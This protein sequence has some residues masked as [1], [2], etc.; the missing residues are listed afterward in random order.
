MPAPLISIITPAYNHEKYIA[1]CIRSALAQ[2]YTNWEMI[3]IDDGSTDRTGAIA[4]SFHDPRIRYLSQTHR[5]PYKL[6]EIYNK[7]L[8]ESKG[9]FIAILEGDDFWPNDKLSRQIASFDQQD[10]ILSYG[11]CIIVDQYGLEL[12]YRPIPADKNIRDNTPLGSALK[13]LLRAENFIYAQTVMIRKT[14]LLKSGG[15][16]QPNY[17]R[18]VDF[19]TWCC[20]ALQGQF[21]AIPNTLGYWRRNP[22][23]ITLSDPLVVSDEFV[24]YIS[25]FLAQRRNEIKKLLPDI[26][27]GNLIAENQTRLAIAQ[28]QRLYTKG[29]T[30][31]IY[32]YNQPARKSFGLYLRQPDKNLFNSIISLLFIIFSYTDLLK[33][34]LLGIGIYSNRWLA[35]IKKFLLSGSSGQE[36]S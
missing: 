31:L 1:D 23:S 4:G 16:I 33:I 19:P 3:I 35:S 28:S 14:A 8:K 7:A 24:R 20:L 2:T 34:T 26:N 5:G 32:G 15:F 13:Q 29:L 22:K 30:L 27:T 11:Q 36:I 21:K 17:L 10:I 12:F 25:E 9:E 18:L 6:G